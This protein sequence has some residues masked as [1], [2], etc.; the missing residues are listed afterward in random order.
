MSEQDVYRYV[1]QV[2][3]HFAD[4]READQLAVSAALA[5]AEKAVNTAKVASDEHLRVHNEVLKGWQEDRSTFATREA[6]DE[7]REQ[8]DARF[9]RLE[10]FQARLLGGM[11]VIALIGL[12]NLV[13]LW[14][15]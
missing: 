10:S 8:D 6:T 4:L 11:G 9:K 5:A 13:K 15:T 7:H 14:L 2:E 3:E 12:G 1:K